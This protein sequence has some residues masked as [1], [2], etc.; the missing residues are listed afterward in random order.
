MGRIGT[1]G[2]I[3][4]VSFDQSGKFCT[5]IVN[6]YGFLFPFCHFFHFEAGLMIALRN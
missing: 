5:N 6:D 1:N 3:G 4:K 2:H